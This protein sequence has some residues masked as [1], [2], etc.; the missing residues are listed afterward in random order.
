MSERLLA[1]LKV[2]DRLPWKLDADGEPLWLPVV[3]VLSSIGYL[4][5]RPDGTTETLTDSE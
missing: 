3:E 5:E 4:I 1:P 2:K